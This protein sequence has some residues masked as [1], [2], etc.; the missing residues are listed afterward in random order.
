VI[1]PN[2]ANAG[3]TAELLNNNAI[4]VAISMS[5]P[6]DGPQRMKSSVAERAR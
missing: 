5:I 4:I 2:T 6:A 3:A 1:F